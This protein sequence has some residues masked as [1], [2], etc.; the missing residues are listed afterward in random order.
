VA[1]ALRGS[2][3]LVGAAAW[4]V[5]GGNPVEGSDQSLGGGSPKGQRLEV[6]R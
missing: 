5:G 3:N 6:G 4:G 1:A 2:G